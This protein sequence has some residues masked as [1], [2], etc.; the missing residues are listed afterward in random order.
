MIKLEEAKEYKKEKT[1]YNWHARYST[2]HK[3][4][5]LSYL[6][7]SF[8]LRRRVPPASILIAPLANIISPP[9]KSIFWGPQPFFKLKSLVPQLQNEKIFIFLVSKPFRIW[10][11]HPASKCGFYDAVSKEITR[12][13]DTKVRKNIKEMESRKMWNHVV[14]IPNKLIWWIQKIVSERKRKW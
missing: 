7:L 1:S 9:R 10:S 8:F 12:M 13:V 14:W 3:Q 11:C 4:T 2:L 6:L 5:P